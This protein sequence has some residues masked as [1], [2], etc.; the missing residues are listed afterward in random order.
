MW[1]FK[2]KVYRMW[3]LQK[4]EKSIQIA[5]EKVNFRYFEKI[6]DYNSWFIKDRISRPK[7]FFIFEAIHK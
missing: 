2:L 4:R 7:D 6:T 5:S 3:E 1:I